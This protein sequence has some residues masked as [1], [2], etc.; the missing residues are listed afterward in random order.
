MRSDQTTAPAASRPAPRPHAPATAAAPFPRQGTARLTLAERAA[1]TDER[2]RDCR[3]CRAFTPAPCGLAY[4][5]CRAH[6]M[7][8]KLYHPPAGFYSQCQFKVLTRVVGSP[9]PRR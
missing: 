2:N 3:S 7:Y 9:E 8:V 1:R 4:G 5:W 6:A